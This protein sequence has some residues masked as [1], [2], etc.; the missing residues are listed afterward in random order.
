MI[1]A[2]RRVIAGNKPVFLLLAGPNGAGK[3]TF[4]QKRL[5]PL[6]FPCID[7][8]A[9]ALE[10]FGRHPSTTAEALKATEKATQRV[11]EHLRN[12]RSIALETVF[13]D[14]KGHKLALLAEARAA[15]FRTVLIYIGVDHPQISIARVMDRVEL[16]GHDVPDELIEARFP[17]C[18]DNLKLALGMVDLTLLVD[19]SGA[20]G[21]KGELDEGLRHYEFGVVERAGDM[22]ISDPVPDW[23]VR[24]QIADAAVAA[25]RQGR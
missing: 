8:D 12:G 18:F 14:V 3:S 24:F 19:N 21:P 22:E 9:V 25:A 16:G 1:D 2:V 4:R 23:Y 17:R 13:S 7:P 6:A 20:Y 10:L 15:G 5:E 11:R